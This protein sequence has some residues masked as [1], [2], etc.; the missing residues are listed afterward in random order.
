MTMGQDLTSCGLV[1]KVIHIILL[2]PHLLKPSSFSASP[3]HL[4]LGF[5]VCIS[6][7]M[8]VYINLL[9]DPPGEG[10]SE[11]TQLI[12]IKPKRIATFVS[13]VSCITQ[14]RAFPCMGISIIGF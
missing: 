14:V 5:D 8:H 11:L 6:L 12:A 9:K 3:Q 4:V 13:S 2:L 10:V 1:W 7:Y